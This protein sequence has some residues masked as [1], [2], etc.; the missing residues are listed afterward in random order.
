M[1]PSE[2]LDHNWLTSHKKDY[3]LNLDVINRLKSFQAPRRLQTEF[4]LFLSNYVKAD[5]IK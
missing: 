3:K 1:T 5:E 4:L 2:A